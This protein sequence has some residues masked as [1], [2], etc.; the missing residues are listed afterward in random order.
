MTLRPEL[1]LLQKTMVTVEGVARGIDPEHDIWSAAEPVVG[2]WIQRELSPATAL[3]RF[4]DEARAAIRALAR[5]AVETRAAAEHPLD[6]DPTESADPWQRF[7]L[8]VL[9]AVAAFC[10]GLLLR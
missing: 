7:A 10:V 4:F 2:R 3:R 9:T 1:I 5:L 8:G 6:D